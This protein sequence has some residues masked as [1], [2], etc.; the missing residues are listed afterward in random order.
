MSRAL[1]RLWYGGAPTPA[2]LRPLLGAGEAV[3][4]AGVA[5]RNALFDRGW[6]SSGRPAGAHIISV[7]NL[8]AGGMGKTPVVCFL[9]RQLLG[10]GLRVAVLTRGHG[11][12][13][14]EDVS[15]DARALPT[16]ERVGDEPRLLAQR[17][18]GLT[19]YVGR[20]RRSLAFRAREEGAEVLLLDDGF[21]HRRLARGVDIVVADEAAGF[22]GGALLPRG[23]LREPPRALTRAH[24]VWWFA[25]EGTEPELPPG[26]SVPMVRARRGLSAV[27]TPQ[28]ATAPA[29]VLAGQAVVLLSGIARPER[30]ERALRGAGADV[31]GTA[32]HADH[33]RFTAPELAEAQALAAREGAW[34]VTT[35]KDAQRLPDGAAH[36]LVEEV[37]L[38]EG[39]SALGAALAR[40]GL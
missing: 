34:L 31:R 33:H 39:Q 25:G 32:F 10:Q 4:A 23:P 40:A 17:C 9:A 13:A 24:L 8:H 7:G 16:A 14:T 26:V 18:P 29:L 6:L 5:A 37:E 15:F 22:G 3:Y 28:G 21:Q 2:W 12:V 20:D 38:L 19:L 35:E 11:R 27:R 36:V 30:V 1:E